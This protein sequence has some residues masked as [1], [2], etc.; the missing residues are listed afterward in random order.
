MADKAMK[1]MKWGAGLV[2]FCV[3]RLSEDGAP[4]PKYIV[5]ILIMNS[6]LCSYF[7][8]RICL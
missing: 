3:C 8:E 2:A 5:V 7:I 4:V 6:L 1:W